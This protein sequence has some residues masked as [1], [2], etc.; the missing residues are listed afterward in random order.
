VNKKPKW[1]E[2][3]IRHFD[4][5]SRLE[6]YR[7]LAE[8]GKKYRRTV[9]L[10]LTCGVILTS[11]Q[12]FVPFLIG[13][14]VSVISSSRSLANVLTISLE[15]VGIS[16]LSSVFQFGLGY[17]GQYLG[18]K[19]IY[20][21]RN[22][23]FA[24]IQ[25][26]SFSFHDSNQT[27]QLMARATG[28]VEAVRRFL[29]FGFPQL[30][31]QILLMIGVPIALF[32][33]NVDFGL[34]V[35]VAL[36]VLV[37]IS[38]RFSQ[39]QAPFWAKARLNYGEI[40][41][42][43][44]ENITGMKIVRAFSAEDH[45]IERFQEKN[46][47]YRDDI[48]GAAKIRSFYTPLLTLIVSLTLGAIYFAGGL[49]VLGLPSHSSMFGDA[50][51]SGA[52]LVALLQGPVRFLGQMILIL[53]NGMAGF[54]RVLDITEASVEVKDR[55]G[56]IELSREKVLGD[57][58]FENVRFGYGKDREIL[59]GINLEITPGEK[60]AFIG[61]T[62][63]G[64]TTLANLV[65][66][67]YDV[68]SGRVMIDGIDVRDVKLKS[69]RSN[70]GI[71][72]QD[73]FLFSASV[74][75]NISYGRP[76]TPIEQVVRAAK[77]ANVDEFVE[78][79]PEGYDTLVGERGITLSGGQKQRIAIARTLITDPKIMIMDDSL[80]SV[81]VQTEY[82]IQDALR[83]VVEGRTTIIITQ[84]LSTL[85]LTDRIVVF[86]NGR[87][88]EQGEHDELLALNGVYARLYY[89]QL[90]PQKYA[91]IVEIDGGEAL[92]SEAVQPE[93]VGASASDPVAKSSKQT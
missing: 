91:E 69:L 61:A 90:A 20:D 32:F 12:V 16:A 35:A 85:R 18:Q 40:N 25:G 19:I 3:L 17:G 15:I 43:L 46:T 70:I 5:K 23:I 56:A 31:G 50:V 1:R 41:A 65:P 13:D 60:V 92:S 27:G 75:E 26:Q 67:F 72:S 9:A 8:Y 71:V 74:R 6:K 86:E 77:I 42:V 44:Q 88:A 22:R 78:R 37:Y 93:I 66:R 10:M 58:V 29:A 14:A 79:F 68:T 84:R 63:S 36:P 57:I 73:I 48:I 30:L 45:E 82:A 4:L 33:L 80:S 53:Q 83:A 51:V 47:E 55:P 39:T 81:D 62:G 64:K 11:L 34:I 52:F 28:D 21:M 2:T 89:S 38:W 87:I 24:T 54:S 59:K 7:K 49:E 76:N